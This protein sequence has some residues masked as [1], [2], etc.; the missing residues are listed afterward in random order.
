MGEGGGYWTLLWIQCSIY[1][2]ICMSIGFDD[3]FDKSLI[4]IKCLS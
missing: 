1:S 4:V 3:A 2:T